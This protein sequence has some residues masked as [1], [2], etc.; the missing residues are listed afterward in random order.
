V[1]QSAAIGVHPLDLVLSRRFVSP[2]RVRAD[3]MRGLSP[4][5]AKAHPPKPHGAV[6]RIGMLKPNLQ[7]SASY[8]HWHY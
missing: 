4:A 6:G 8:V 3:V 7:R 2:G 5:R 1:R